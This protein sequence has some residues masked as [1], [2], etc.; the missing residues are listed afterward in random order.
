MWKLVTSVSP[1]MPEQVMQ[2]RE[3]GSVQVLLTT[4]PEYLAWLAEGN[5]PEPADSVAITQD[6]DNNAV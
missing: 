3:D 2:V 4:A 1:T 5:T 6:E